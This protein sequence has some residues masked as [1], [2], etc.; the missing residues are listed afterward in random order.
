MWSFIYLLDQENEVQMEIG[1]PERLTLA[2]MEKE[3][4]QMACILY[5]C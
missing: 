1:K 2:S 4:E 3:V 5:L